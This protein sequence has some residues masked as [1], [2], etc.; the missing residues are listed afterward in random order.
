MS[1][2]SASAVAANSPSSPKAVGAAPSSTA[3][4]Q[5]P[6]L[7]EKH[8]AAVNASLEKYF[9]LSQELG[10]PIAEQVRMIFVSRQALFNLRIA[11]ATLVK[12][13]VAA[14]RD[15]L[16]ISA[17][18]Q[19]PDMGSAT[20]MK[21][22]EPIQKALASIIEIKD[23]NRPSPLFNNLSTVAEGIPALGW[24]TCVST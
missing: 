9:N 18:A 3:S 5:T 16:Y 10:G 11:Q 8:D 20:F 12:Q 17:L 19:K 21:L 24:F 22:L 23:A 7:V 6:A 13:A 1:S 2:S 15:I 14:E 4:S